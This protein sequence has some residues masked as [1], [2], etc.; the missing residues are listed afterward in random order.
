MEVTREFGV[1]LMHC[2][3]C[4]SR[5]TNALNVRIPV[6]P[7]CLSFGDIVQQVECDSLCREV[8]FLPL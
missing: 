6:P 8:L 3:K 5:I 4:E 2:G 7:P 1:D